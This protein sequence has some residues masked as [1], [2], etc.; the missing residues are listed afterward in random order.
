MQIRGRG[1]RFLLFITLFWTALPANADT[2]EAWRKTSD[3]TAVSLGVAAFG[4]GLVEQD[5][6]GFLQGAK[7]AT[8]TFLTV[9]GLKRLVSKERPDQSD[10][11]SFPSGHTALAFAAAGYIDRRYGTQRPLLAPLAYGL[12][13]TTALSRVKAEKHFAA[14]VLAGALIGWT[15]AS[16]FT[17]SKNASNHLTLDEKGNI[18]LVYEKKF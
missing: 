9:E 14:D 8:T 6:E 7:A 16:I 18:N 1:C 3:V 4:L 10:K 17:T 5:R 12:A 13:T 2:L 11:R 15:F